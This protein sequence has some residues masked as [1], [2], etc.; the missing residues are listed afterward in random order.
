MKRALLLFFLL[1]TVVSTTT[2]FA[3]DD[4]E[5]RVIKGIVLDEK[6]EPLTGASVAVVGTT[7]GA[8]TNA[9]GEF[10]IKLR[11]T[12]DVKLRVSFIGYLPQD[13]IVKADENTRTPLRI[14]LQPSN[15]ELLEVVVTGSPLE[16]PLKDIPVET[17]LI[18]Q[19]EIQALNP[20]NFET[21]LQYELPGLQIGYNFMSQMPTMKYQGVNGD[22]VL[23]LIDGERVSG[24]GSSGNVDFTR[25][26][27]NEI[28]RIE[29]VKGAQSTIYGSNA[30]GGVINIITKKANRP[31]TG[32]VSARFAGQYG[33][34]YTASAGIKKSKYSTF[35]SLTHRVRRTYSV[36]DPSG[37]IVTTIAPDGTEIQ[38][39]EN[40]AATTIYGGKIWNFTQK[41]GYSF[42]DKLSA[43]V[44][45]TYY[46]NYHDK[47]DYQVFRNIFADYTLSG[48]V[49]YLPTSK[50][51]LGLSYIFDNYKKDKDYYMVKRVR[52]DYRNRTQTA[53]LTY[54]Y[55]GAKHTFS[56]GAEYNHEYL[57]H[58]MMKDSADAS[59]GMGS[60]Y[61]QE[62]WTPS[63]VLNVTLGVRADYHRKYQWNFSPKISLLFRSFE[64]LALR[65]GYSQGFRSPTLKELYQAYDMGGLGYFMIY[66]NSELRPER[67]R[68][69]SVS[70]EYTFGKF[71]CSLSYF[72]YRFKDQIV[73]VRMDGSNDLT[74]VNSEKSRTRGLEFICKWSP[75]R[76]F[77]LSGSYAYVKDYQEVKGKNTSYTRPHSFTFSTMYNRQIGKVKATLSL[78]G[79]WASKLTTYVFKTDNS[80]TQTTYAPRFLC[81]LNAGVQLPRGISAS[82]GIDNLFNYKDKASESNL[83]LPQKGT[84]LIG[85]LAINLADMF[86]L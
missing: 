51:E 76:R 45:G 3:I 57:K 28:E 82:I 79:Q 61:I 49:K 58:Y 25:F 29:V 63:D 2:V 38:T 24:E 64:G 44:K 14:C 59:V 27:V 18:T 31:F 12:T 73:L 48:K 66:G 77:T 74:Y 83:Q 62:D 86:N 36:E 80:F 11:S 40:N 56:T 4:I 22:Y 71:N 7:I 37:K 17:R 43:E 46:Y 13:V 8:G 53:K 70:A 1:Q 65:A 34:T 81:V 6:N 16:K 84:S 75:S 15:N 67:S 41:L 60:L 30:L 39:L 42:T 20:A 55:I 9:K 68:Q 33:E 32:N 85:T 50:Q 10:L 19:K 72:R 69:Y 35:T 54:S 5:E 26:D 23:F 47:R 78:N 21:L 52:T